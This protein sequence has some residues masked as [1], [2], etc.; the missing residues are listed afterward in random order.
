M[1]EIG[2]LIITRYKVSGD[3]LKMQFH[4]ESYTAE[5][6]SIQT[7]LDTSGFALAQRLEIQK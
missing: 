2:Q 3:I 7:F 4:I 6:S 5:S 1:I